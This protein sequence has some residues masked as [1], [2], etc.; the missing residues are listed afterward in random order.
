MGLEPSL[1]RS[2]QML[3]IP[4][5]IV[6]NGDDVSLCHAKADITSPGNSAFRPQML[7]HKPSVKVQEG[8]Q[9]VVGI[10]VNDDDFKIPV[11]LMVET[12]E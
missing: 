3:G 2:Q 11:T 12:A 5:V 7:N 10:L 4:T 9:S 6:G 1:D 8:Q